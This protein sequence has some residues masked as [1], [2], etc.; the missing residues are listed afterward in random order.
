MPSDGT[1]VAKPETPGPDAGQATD[2]DI[3]RL[4]SRLEREFALVTQK[5]VDAEETI[6][7]IEVSL[8]TYETGSRPRLPG[9][10][11]A[12]SSEK[13]TE[14]ITARLKSVGDSFSKFKDWVVKPKEGGAAEGGTPEGKPPVRGAGDLE[15]RLEDAL[16]SISSEIREREK[17]ATELDRRLHDAQK[18]LIKAR[19]QEQHAREMQIRIGQTKQLSEDLERK[20]AMLD[21]MVRTF[22]S[23]MKSETGFRTKPKEPPAGLPKLEDRLQAAIDEALKAVAHQEKKV[24]DLEREMAKAN[25]ALVEERGRQQRIRGMQVRLRQARHFSSDLQRSL[26]G[27]AASVEDLRRRASSLLRPDTGKAAREPAAPAKPVPTGGAA[28]ASKS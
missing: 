4:R 16:R 8:R 20:M 19:A 14:K 1:E 7:D 23:S 17:E 26:S 18:E 15:D 12:S 27:L 9:G 3:L 25:A 10:G 13:G 22:E 21:E 2:E 24:E 6:V 28:P 11:G 5:L